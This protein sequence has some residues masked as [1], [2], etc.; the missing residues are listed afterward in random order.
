[1][2]LCVFPDLS[3]CVSLSLAL[4]CLAS[5]CP[6]SPPPARPLS[7]PVRGCP[8]SLVR[9]CSDTVARPACWGTCWAAWWRAEKALCVC[10]LWWWHGCCCLGRG[11]AVSRVLSLRER[12][13]YPRAGQRRRQRQRRGQGW[14]NR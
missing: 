12:R 2:F 3:L 10:V 5:D 11:A 7:P 9:T 6:L 4:L 14:A 13:C 1:M 8:F